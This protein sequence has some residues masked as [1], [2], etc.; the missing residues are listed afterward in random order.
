MLRLLNIE[1]YKLWNN[2]MVKVMIFLYFGLLS[3]LVLLSSIRISFG[4][5]TLDLASEGIFDFPLIWN[6][7]TFTASWFKVFLAIIV[8]NS[9]TMEYSG[10]NLETK[11]NRW[12]E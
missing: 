12:F 7:T 4:M 1:L 3:L 11:L 10:K 5:F 9:V 2:R 6:I 8:V